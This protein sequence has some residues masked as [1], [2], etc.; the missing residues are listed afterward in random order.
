MYGKA[1]REVNEVLENMDSRYTR[2]ISPDFM[3]MMIR[4]IDWSYDFKY[5]INKTI[6][7]Q[8]ISEDAKTILSIIYLRYFSTPD[9]KQEF[10][11]QLNTNDIQE[12][13]FKREKYN[14]NKIFEKTRYD[15]INTLEKQVELV[16]IPEKWYKKL[17]NKI[18]VFFKH[19]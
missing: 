19:K 7:E 12:E 14:P 13:N 5:D 18:K 4:N 3:N 6:E 16:K 9:E 8:E 11:E 15:D 17:L 2:L 1:L 10:M